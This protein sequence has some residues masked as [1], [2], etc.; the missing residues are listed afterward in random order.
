MLL[1]AR[2]PRTSRLAS[3]KKCKDCAAACGRCGQFTDE[4]GSN[5]LLVGV[6]WLV[7]GRRWL[8]FEVRV[9][10][11]RKLFIAALLLAVGFGVARLM[12]HP[13]AHWYVPQPGDVAVA[14][15]SPPIAAKPV[16]SAAPSPLIP[17]G[18]RLV[19][20]FGTNNP[21]QV[22][23]GS[24]LPTATPTSPNDVNSVASALAPP[25]LSTTND[26]QLLRP[27]QT[28][29]PNSDPRAKLRDEAPRPLKIESRA[30]AIVYA[31]PSPPSQSDEVASAPD[32]RSASADWRASGLRPAEFVQDPANIATINASYSQPFGLSN[33]ASTVA[34]PPWPELAEASEPR[35]HIVVD[36]DSLERLAGRYL[37]DANRG[38]EIYEAN[39]E[40]LADPDL[41]PIGAQ[42]VI[43]KR[44]A[45]AA[46][47]GS[48][49]QSSLANDP[50]V[51][52]ATNRG[53]VPVRPIPSAVGLMPRAQLLPPMAA[54]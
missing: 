46:F 10:A 15:P 1:G 12:G 7:T 43:P 30:P 36:G 19:P 4:A 9:T 32:A 48:S 50:S 47:E 40:L 22:R 16:R 42:L 23:T 35:T 33:R 34:P 41:L 39:R 53:M 37:D 52:A 25:A 51:R 31:Q 3:T 21:Y 44:S 24:T 29:T 13:A 45:R 28:A 6:T 49:P 54:E 20:D 26:Y 17:N 11:T 18:A 14:R 2:I 38:N 27:N 5:R 8:D